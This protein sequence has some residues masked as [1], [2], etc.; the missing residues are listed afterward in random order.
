MMTLLKMAFLG[1]AFLS[2]GIMFPGPGMP[3]STG[4]Y[5]CTGS[6]TILC[7]SNGAAAATVTLANPTGS[8]N[9]L[10]VG[11]NGN[12]ST[13][14]TISDTG[15][16]TFTKMMGPIFA[17]N[18][19]AS[20][21]SI[22]LYCGS[23]ST[24]EPA[25]VIS[26]TGSPYGLI[27]GEFHNAT[28]TADPYAPGGV[29]SY[30]PTSSMTSGALGTNNA[31]DYLIGLFTSGGALPWTLT[32]TMTSMVYDSSGSGLEMI[33]QVVTSTGSYAASAT[34]AASSEWAAFALGLE[35]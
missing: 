2:Q 10:I 6:A 19:S 28:C 12:Y 35:K 26:T 31:T 14:P 30:G 25:D 4:S 11:V 16:N 22:T 17:D 9:T 33:Y 34:T 15:G 3:A 23:I 18:T 5:S 24:T 13:A 20:L 32:G 29:H 1:L 27:V 8:G 7:Q 21:N